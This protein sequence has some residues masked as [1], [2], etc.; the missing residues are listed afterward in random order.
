V[1]AGPGGV[2]ADVGDAELAAV[3]GDAAGDARLQSGVAQPGAR[4]VGVGERGHLAG[5]Q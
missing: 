4:A 1:D 5:D 3:A 2:F